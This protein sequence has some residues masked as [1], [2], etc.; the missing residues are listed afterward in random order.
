ME[1]RELALELMKK[2]DIEFWDF[3]FD[4]AK[5]RFGSCRYH[6]RYITL[7]KHLV[8]LN[9]YEIVKDTILH[10]IAHALVGPGNGHNWVWRQKAIEIGC[11]GKRCYDTEKVNAVI[12]K[13]VAECPNCKHKFYKHRKLKNRRRGCGKCKHL[14]FSERILNY[15]PNISS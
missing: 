1:A 15:Q 2:H 3:K 5:N 6:S 11:N 8:Q 10:E 12:G 14:P 9:D 4:N 13:L 7:S